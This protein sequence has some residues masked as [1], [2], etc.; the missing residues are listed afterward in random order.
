M[1]FLGFVSLRA[2]FLS[3]GRRGK[4]G[5][6]KSAQRREFSCFKTFNVIAQARCPLFSFVRIANQYRVLKSQD[7][8]DLT[9][10]SLYCLFYKARKSSLSSKYSVVEQNGGSRR[11]AA[12]KQIRLSCKHVKDWDESKFQSG[13]NHVQRIFKIH[14]IL[15]EQ[16]IVMKKFLQGSNVYFSA[17]IGFLESLSS[18]RVCLWSFDCWMYVGQTTFHK[19]CAGDL[20]GTSHDWSS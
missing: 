5:T 1:I 3:L 8:I 16:K 17:P 2:D 18:F 10:D 14:R 12:R 7:P 4:K 13:L 6:T 20:P 15:D 11:E 9:K 19:H